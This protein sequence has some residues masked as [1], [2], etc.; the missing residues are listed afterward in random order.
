MWAIHAKAHVFETQGRHQEGYDF[1]MS[2]KTTWSKSNLA[3]HCYWHIGLCLLELGKKD[4]ALL[5]YDE[6]AILM[7]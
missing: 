1:L 3:C 4:D 6:V 7:P 2:K 5:N